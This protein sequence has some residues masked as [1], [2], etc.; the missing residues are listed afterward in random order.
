MCHGYKLYKQLAAFLYIFLCHAK[1][2]VFPTVIVIKH[3]NSRIV[4]QAI[5]FICAGELGFKTHEQPLF[6]DKRLFEKAVFL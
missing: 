5:K 1:A 2:V 4:E 3:I 6:L